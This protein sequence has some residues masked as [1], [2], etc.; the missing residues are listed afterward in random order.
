ML[1]QDERYCVND[2]GNI[3]TAWE[4]LNVG[5]GGEIYLE[6]AVFIRFY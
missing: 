3:G 2:L 1:R 6:L 5:H 4:T